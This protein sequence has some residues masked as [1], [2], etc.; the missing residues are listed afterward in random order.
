MIKPHRIQLKRERGWKIPPNTLKVDRSTK[1]G[2][3]FSADQ[4]GRERAVELHRAWLTGEMLE[5]A[6][7]AS[8]PSIIAKHLISRRLGVMQSLSAV[9]GR[10]LACW[11]PLQAP[12]H[13]DLLIEL[14]NAPIEV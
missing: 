7:K 12:C 14:A 8:Y 1:F 3:P 10:N 13:A 2:N 5:A 9:R 4:Y 11:C 6:I